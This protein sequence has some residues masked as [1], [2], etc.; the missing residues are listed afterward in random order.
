MTTTFNEVSK[1]NAANLV[2]LL[3]NGDSISFW[4][5]DES[6]SFEPSHIGCPNDYEKSLSNLEVVEK[7]VKDFLKINPENANYYTMCS[8]GVEA[9]NF[10]EMKKTIRTNAIPNW[11]DNSFNLKEVSSEIEINSP[12]QFWCFY[13][14]FEDEM[15]RLS[16]KSN[17]WLYAN[18]YLNDLSLAFLAREKFDQFNQ[19]K[20]AA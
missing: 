4:E 1:N 12:P 17:R 10:M 11:D 7:E 15:N 19:Q 5:K 3:L 13:P 9:D 6:F 14:H 8:V 2:K 16:K 20:I 18:G